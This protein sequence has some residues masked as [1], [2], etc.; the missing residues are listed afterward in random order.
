MAPLRGSGLAGS[1]GLHDIGQLVDDQLEDLDQ[2]RNVC[3]A[4]R[5][6]GKRRLR[7]RPAELPWPRR[8]S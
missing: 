7:V 6:W 5:V 8:P 3:P 2:Q 4:L 1:V